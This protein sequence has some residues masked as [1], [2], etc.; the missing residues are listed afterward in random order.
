MSDDGTGSSWSM[1]RL[2]PMAHIDG[3][4]NLRSESEVLK[5]DHILQI[6]AFISTRQR[7]FKT[8]NLQSSIVLMRLS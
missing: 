4:E 7:L 3:S 2:S 6:L 5:Y 1:I 8:G